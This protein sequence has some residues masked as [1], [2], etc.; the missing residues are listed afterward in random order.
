MALLA[1]DASVR[2]VRVFNSLLR[3]EAGES[4]WVQWIPAGAMA[5][6]LV[7]GG[8]LNYRLY[9]DVQAKDGRVWQ[10]FSPIETTVA[11]EVAARMDD[12][13][14]YLSP[15]LYHFSPLRF[16]TYR[17]AAQGGGGLEHPAYQLADPVTDL[18]ISD[19]FAQD[20]LFLLDTYYQDVP[21]LFTAYYP[22]T[23]FELVEGP[24]GNPLYLSVT[25]PGDEIAALQGSL[26]VYTQQTGTQGVVETY[27]GGS[28]FAWPPALAADAGEDATAG[29]VGSLLIPAS[30]LYDFAVDGPGEFT[31]D[32]QPWS[33]QQFLGKG[34]HAFALQQSE[35]GAD[36]VIVVSW[37][38]PGKGENELIPPNYFF[39]V[40]PPAHG[41][42]GQYFEGELWEGE[43]A[44]TRVD[45]MLLFAWPEAEPW[46]APFSARW[47]GTLTTPSS[48][49]YRFQLNADDGVRMW[50]DGELVGES[51]RP[52]NVNMVDAEVALDAGPHDIRIDYFQRGGGKALEFWWQPPGE[53]LRPVPP[54]VLSP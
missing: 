51:V 2:S 25:V 27:T 19:P 42:T 22:G 18:P 29:W 46:P 9:F 39:T 32:G 43:P 4:R 17:S 13:S 52:D 31:L 12:A 38:L 50:L 44:F 10:A 37:L 21:E 7:W 23:T 33:G 47:T 54:G 15:R 6:L 20:A 53:Q 1:G 35:P 36:A 26:G 48:G 24:G 49:V 16:L 28:R 40:A 30:G 11:S 8:T 34:L 3:R 41:L 45:P 14:L 5:L